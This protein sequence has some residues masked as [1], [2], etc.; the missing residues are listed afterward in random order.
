MGHNP[1]IFF[2]HNRSAEPKQNEIVI[3]KER[4]TEVIKVET[5]DVELT[6]NFEIGKIV[7]GQIM[8]GWHFVNDVAVS[9]K[10]QTP[11]LMDA[12]LHQTIL[13]R[14]ATGTVEVRTID[15]LKITTAP[16]EKSDL[17]VT[18]MKEIK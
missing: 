13:L 6:M 4:V 5:L 3:I 15:V 12:Y 2:T 9:M 11:T 18:Y 10:L 1:L 17:T 16:A 8:A 7:K 14:T